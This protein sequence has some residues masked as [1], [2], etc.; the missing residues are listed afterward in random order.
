MRGRKNTRAYILGALI[1]SVFTISLGFAAF[2]TILNISAKAHMVLDRPAFS[3]VF[4]SSNESYQTNAVSPTK[5][6][7]SITTTDGTINNTE[8]PTISNLSALFTD[9]GQTV[10]YTFYVHNNGKVAAYLNSI[11]FNGSKTCTTVSG[12]ANSTHV[13][14][15]CDSIKMEISYNGL[16]YSQTTSGIQEQKINVGE[17]K[18]VVVT[19]QYPSDGAD[20]DESFNVNFPNI[21]LEYSDKDSDLTPNQILYAL[22]D[23]SDSSVTTYDDYHSLLQDDK[24][25]F[26]KYEV[27]KNN[28][29]VSA[30]VCLEGAS[31][32]SDEDITCFNVNNYSEVKSQFQPLCD[33]SSYSVVNDEGTEQETYSCRFALDTTCPVSTNSLNSKSLKAF[34]ICFKTY[35][36]Q[37]AASGS[38]YCQL[39]GYDYPTQ[40]RIYPDYDVYCSSYED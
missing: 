29:N 35:W 25:I 4:S 40:C 11:N 37:A 9:T 5:S 30:S 14:S 27:D 2:S 10:T 8:E 22:G 20:T 39:S 34:Q 21:S 28:R 24:P 31:G 6:D 19:L 7:S 16:T 26:L 38:I 1:L 12:N 13:N 23:R 3:V 36:C 15:A 18:P 32:D 33:N 17:F